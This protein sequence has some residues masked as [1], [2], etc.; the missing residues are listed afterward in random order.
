MGS[1]ILVLIFT[2]FMALPATFRA[3]RDLFGSWVSDAS[4]SPSGA[5]LALHAAFVTL[6]FLLTQRSISTFIENGRAYSTCKDV[7]PPNTPPP[8]MVSPGCLTQETF[9]TEDIGVRCHIKGDPANTFYGWVQPDLVTCNK[10][11]PKRTVSFTKY[12]APA[13]RPKIM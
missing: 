13:P 2:L 7:A 11:P 5:G 10:T 3:S 8:S 12:T 6:L 1:L 4:G 9:D